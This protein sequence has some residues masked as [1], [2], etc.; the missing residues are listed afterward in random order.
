MLAFG[1]SVLESF[2]IE[3][4]ALGKEKAEL[5]WLVYSCFELSFIDLLL[6]FVLFDV[7]VV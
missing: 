1:A 3:A 7:D 5:Q 2:Q 6:S 4:T